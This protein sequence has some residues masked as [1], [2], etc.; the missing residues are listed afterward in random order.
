MRIFHCDHCHALVFFENFQCLNC[1]NALAFLPDL[2]VIGS[3]EP[4]GPVDQGTASADQPQLWQSP[5]A[6]AENR[7]YRL[8]RNYTDHNVCNFAVPVDVPN[9]YCISC[10]LTRLLP[11]LSAPGNQE[12][13]YRIEVAKRRLLYTLLALKLPVVSR[14]EDPQRGLE[15][16]FLADLPGGPQVMTG[17]SDGTITINIAESDDAVRAQRREALH[18][19]Y[20][21][22]LGHF[23]HEIGHYYWDRLISGSPRLEDFRALFGDERADY[24]QALH[25]HY[26]EG[27]PPDWGQRFVSAYASSHAWEDWAETWAHY[28]HMADTL[29]TASAYGI[30]LNP[31]RDNA[32]SLETSPDPMANPPTFDDMLR[33]WLPLT[34]MLNSLNR[35]LGQP[36]GYPFSLPQPAIDKLRFVHDTIQMAAPA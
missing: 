8:C 27:P 9:P 32:L 7:R 30:S 4:V 34:F 24:T 21:T 15:Y 28:L 5:A 18:E 13:W 14:A 19:P 1:G 3:I 12:K 31:E 2:A 16:Q 11:D 29:E 35:G 6:G 22:L 17:H 26:Q 10:R 20:R 33:S 23:R 25:R 36:D